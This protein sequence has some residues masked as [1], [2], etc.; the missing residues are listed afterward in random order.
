MGAVGYTRTK[1]VE[2]ILI[3]SKIHAKTVGVWERGESLVLS[4]PR[5]RG[6]ATVLE[7]HSR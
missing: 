6:C 4:F 7:P 1:V 2:N 5:P 3:V